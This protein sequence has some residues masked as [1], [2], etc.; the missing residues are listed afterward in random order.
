MAEAELVTIRD[1]GLD[2][3]RYTANG[4]MIAVGRLTEDSLRQL[5]D[6]AEALAEYRPERRSIEAVA[7]PLPYELT[8]VFDAYRRELE[9]ESIYPHPSHARSEGIG[10]MLD[11]ILQTQYGVGEE[12]ARAILALL[13]ADIRVIGT[14]TSTELADLM[15]RSGHEGQRYLSRTMPDNPLVYFEGDGK[16]HKGKRF[17]EYS[18]SEQLAWA[19]RTAQMIVAGNPQESEILPG[20]RASAAEALAQYGAREVAD[21]TAL[22]LM[23]GLG[24]M[25]RLATHQAFVASTVAPQDAPATD[26]PEP[27]DAPVT[28]EKR[29]LDPTGGPL[30]PIFGGKAFS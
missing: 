21:E 16:D 11:V 23:A 3:M 8:A 12:G 14:D 9:A 19:A 6:R 17:S 20:V 24:D 13:H 1:F 30:K 28:E 7:L 4:H 18:D 25:K 27:V 10:R 15:Q 2:H 5:A 26:S 29:P 22:F